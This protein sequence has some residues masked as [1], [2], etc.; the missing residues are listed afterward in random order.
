MAQ[1]SDYPL[2]P[3]ILEALEGLG[4]KEPSP[5]QE[6][7]IP[8]VLEGSDLIG[9][10]ETGSGKT[11]ACAIPVC[12]RVDPSRIEVQALIVVPTRELALQYATETQKIGRRKGVKAYA[13]FGGE[14]QSLQ[15]AKL[16]SGV[17][18]LIATPGRLIDLIFRRLIDLSHVET[19]VLD[20]ADEMLSMGFYDD[21]EMII[22]CLV[23]DHQT[24]LFSAT[25]PKQIHA[26]AQQH[27]RS[28]KEVRLTR[29]QATP[30]NIEHN[31]VYCK[32]LHDKE[33]HLVKLLK[34][35]EPRQSIIFCKS[36]IQAE[37]VARF[38]QRQLQGV[39]FL[40]GG[41][42]QDLR[43][44]ITGKFR[45]GKVR[46]LVA[47][48]VASR[49][50]DFAGVTHVFMVHIPEEDDLYIHRSGRTGRSGRSGVSVALVSDRELS[51]LER[52]LKRLPEGGV[53]WL[54]APP[55]EKGGA[56]RPPRRHPSKRRTDSPS[57]E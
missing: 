38:L 7:S 31:F 5:I 47:T 25:M 39:D 23:H 46:H 55:P 18:V 52:I 42:S 56:K 45:S 36:R 4:F 57:A 20:E 43:T 49:G 35:M 10:A 16:K 15:E 21:L 13:L 28:P 29:S 19:L 50:L 34:E 9:L 14:E 26:I 24:L 22:Q 41:L 33:G 17:Q 37:K 54:G 48:D 11:A 27:M 12:H 6:A 3:A 51:A 2:D 32:S 40:H 44:I 1:F 53:K 8:I 30:Q